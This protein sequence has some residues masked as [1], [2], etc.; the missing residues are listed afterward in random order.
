MLAASS[1]IHPLH[2]FP[3]PT[4]FHTAG[5][6]EGRC[7]RWGRLWLSNWLRRSKLFQKSFSSISPPPR[8]PP[9]A[10]PLV[11][12][13]SWVLLRP[14]V[15]SVFWLVLAM[16]V[17]ILG[18]TKCVWESTSII[19]I[20]W[21]REISLCSI[22]SSGISMCHRPWDIKVGLPNINDMQT[23]KVDLLNIL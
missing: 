5:D 3:V 19:E 4:Y 23:I 15:C 17:F 11:L 12:A 20:I 10:S 8:P 16:L 6:R 9:P 18:T 7:T 1:T 22:L 21:R 14:V 13:S 2:P